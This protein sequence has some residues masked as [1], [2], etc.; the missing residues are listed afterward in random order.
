MKKSKSNPSVFLIGV[1]NI[2]IFFIFISRVASQTLS[3]GVFGTLE[4][5]NIHTN[6]NEKTLLTN[7]GLRYLFGCVNYQD[8]LMTLCRDCLDGAIQMDVERDLSGHMYPFR[9]GTDIRIWKYICKNFVADIST[10]EIDLFVQNVYNRYATDLSGMATIMVAH[11]GATDSTN[12]WGFINHACQQIQ[13]RFGDNVR[14]LAITEV[15]TSKLDPANLPAFV[16]AVPHLDIFMY[17]CYPLRWEF[18]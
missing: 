6:T 17:E 8:N 3:C 16:A 2:F 10:T 18:G 5:A 7:L 15:V 13:T 1:L 11:Q 9:G 12:H 4:P 14:S